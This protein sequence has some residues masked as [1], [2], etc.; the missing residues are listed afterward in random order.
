MSTLRYSLENINISQTAGKLLAKECHLRS[1]QLQVLGQQKSFRN[2]WRKAER[3]TVS[4]KSVSTGKMMRNILPVCKAKPGSLLPAQS[5]GSE[6]HL[7]LSS[8]DQSWGGRK[9]VGSFGF[10]PSHICS[11]IKGGVSICFEEGVCE[12]ISQTLGRKRKLVWAYCTHMDGRQG[13]A[14]AEPIFRGGE[15]SGGK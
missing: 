5:N 14:P 8:E 1:S 13:T 7:E 2:C 9:Q 12:F 15:L 3:G 6:W 4:V 11:F 10:I